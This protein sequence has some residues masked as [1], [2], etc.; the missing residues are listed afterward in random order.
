MK[1]T[2]V[3][4]RSHSPTLHIDTVFCTRQPHSTQ[5]KLVAPVTASRPEGALPETVMV[6][7][8]PGSS[9]ITVTV[10]DL[11]PKLAG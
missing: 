10:A 4:W 6:R 7:G 8:P 5:P 1:A 11:S 9:L 2:S 3:T